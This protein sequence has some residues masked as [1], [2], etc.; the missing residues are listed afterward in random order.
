LQLVEQHVIW[1]NDP[2]YGVI[3]EAAF[4]SKNLYNTANYEYRQAF[5][6]EG[7]YFNYNE[8]LSSRPCPLSRC[9]RNGRTSIKYASCCAEAF[10]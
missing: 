6:H 10:T 8:A 5:I 4:K 9:K 1:K 7:K 3:D 2:R